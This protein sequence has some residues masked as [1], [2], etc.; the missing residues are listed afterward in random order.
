MIRKKQNTFSSSAPHRHVH[1]NISERWRTSKYRFLGPHWTT[2]LCLREASP[3]LSSIS[4]PSSGFS[5]YKLRATAIH[6]QGVGTLKFS[7]HGVKTSGICI[8]D[9][10][11]LKSLLLCQCVFFKNQFTCG[12]PGKALSDLSGQRT[13]L[14]FFFF[15][16]SMCMHYQPSLQ[17]DDL[18]SFLSPFP[19]RQP[20]GKMYQRHVSSSLFF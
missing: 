12:S 16:C 5:L 20:W 18:R 11:K 19:E 3:A 4:T 6:M 1:S 10:P 7:D 9:F 15:L 2:E 13:P 14:L 8:W 17:C